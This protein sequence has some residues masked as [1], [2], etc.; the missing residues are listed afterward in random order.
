M[1]GQNRGDAR[2][3]WA[4][5]TSRDALFQVRYPQFLVRCQHLDGENPDVWSPENACAASIPVCDS[6][7]HAG[8]VLACLAYPTSEFRRSELQAAAFAVSRLDGFP[9]ASECTN[10]WG[11]RDVSDVHDKNIHGVKFQAATVAEKQTSY[12]AEHAIYRTFHKGACYEL[13]VNLSLALDSAFA[14]EDVPRKLPPE[15]RAKINASLTQA[16]DGF[17]FM[18]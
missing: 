1:V 10:R 3:A 6:S 5:I 9:T 18:K 4:T 15:E 8:N 14:A 13:D 7:V 11:S 2:P 16:L 17:R 12:V